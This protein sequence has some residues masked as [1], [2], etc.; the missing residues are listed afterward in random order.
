MPQIRDMLGTVFTDFD[1]PSEFDTFWHHHILSDDPDASHG[2]S[3]YI[4]TAGTGLDYKY[5][6]WLLDLFAPDVTPV[7]QVEDIVVNK[8][9]SA[10][11]V[12][13]DRNAKDATNDIPS[14]TFAG[15]EAPKNSNWKH[16][17]NFFEKMKPAKSPRFIRFN[18]G[19]K[20]VKYTFA[21]N[22][23]TN[24]ALTEALSA[25]FG[26]T[27]LGGSALARI[28]ESVTKAESGLL[29]TL[30]EKNADSDEI[31]VELAGPDL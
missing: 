29:G 5:R 11:M 21:D 9:K 17:K 16:W 27:N 12:G 3:A 13:Y 22:G 6:G 18:S 31:V 10:V 30:V 2:G 4:A 7:Y 24:A 20:N 14:E 8:A 23:A 28:F 26:T 25:V 15:T 19:D 1:H